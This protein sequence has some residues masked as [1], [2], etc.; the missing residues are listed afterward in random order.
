MTTPTVQGFNGLCGSWEGLL[1]ELGG[2]LRKLEEPL[3][4]FTGELGGPLEEA[5]W[6]FGEAREVL[7]YSWEG[8]NGGWEQALAIKGLT[9]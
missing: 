2:P 7:K 3:V 4:E 9:A 1:R 8:L 5:G 6:A